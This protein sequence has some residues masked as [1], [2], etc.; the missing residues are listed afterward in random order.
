VAPRGKLDRGWPLVVVVAS[1]PSFC[2]EQ[3]DAIVAARAADRCR[4]IVV[5]DN[6]KA[7][8]NADIC[9]AADG[10]WWRYHIETIR[11]C[12]F[13][14]ELWSHDLQ[15]ARRFG[16]TPIRGK[17]KAG[18]S[19]DSGVIHNGGNSG[20][21]AIG[22]AFHFGARRIVLVGFDMKRR[23]DGLRHW[24]G[25]HPAPLRNSDPYARLF[26]PKFPDLARDLAREGVDVVNA[27][28][29]TAL[30]CFRR[31]DLETALALPLP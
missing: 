21:Q 17:Q 11:D 1:G 3:A 27:T 10:S 12:G 20:Y 13:A 7:I 16:L 8:P 25:D 24:F 22:L 2:E 18:L 15:A 9:Y 31:A 6:W 23:D 30:D 28:R 26:L 5:N 29:D 14:G 19:T 4:V